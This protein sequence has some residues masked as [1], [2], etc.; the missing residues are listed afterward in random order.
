MK[1]GEGH[2]ENVFIAGYLLKAPV[3]RY[4]GYTKTTF[5]FT[6]TMRGRPRSLLRAGRGP[7]LRRAVS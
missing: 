2:G 4:I 6:D 5:D 3:T 7:V 1:G